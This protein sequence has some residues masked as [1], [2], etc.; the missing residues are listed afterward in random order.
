VDEG[1]AI[2]VSKTCSLKVRS[3]GVTCGLM[4]V[5]LFHVWAGKSKSC[6]QVDAIRHSG[7]GVNLKEFYKPG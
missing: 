4:F 2:C 5:C 7:G 6:L 3:L 1:H